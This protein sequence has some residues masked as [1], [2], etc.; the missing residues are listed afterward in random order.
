M[1]P[2]SPIL[3][4]A[5]LLAFACSSFAQTN[6]VSNQSLE[7]F[8]A[9]PTTLSQIT[10]ATGWGQPT[11]HTGSSD[12]FNSCATSTIS[13]VPTN[14]FGTTTFPAQGNAYAGGYIYVQSLPTYREY[15]VGSLTTPLVAGQSYVVSFHYALAPR[16]RYASDALGFYLSSA[17]PSNTGSNYNVL[18]VTPNS[19]NQTGNYLTSYS[20]QLYSDTIIA[21]GGEQYIT[22][23]SFTANAT[24]TL[25][26]SSAGIGGAYMYFDD[27]SILIHNGVFGDSNICLGDTAELYG[28]F[29]TTF[30]WVDSANPNTVL[31]TNDTIWVAPTQNST[32]WAIEGQDTSSF[33]VY[34]HELPTNFVGPDTTVCEGDTAIRA[35]NLPYNYLWSD[36]ETDSVLHTIQGG[37]HWLE[38]SLYGCSERDTFEVT[39][40][41][42]P[43]FSLP[44]DTTI[45]HY[46]NLTVST[47]LL[48]PLLFSWNTGGNQPSLTVIDSGEY[49]V[50]VTNNNCT[51]YDT[52]QVSYHPELSV[53]LGHD[54][55]FC[56]QSAVPINSVTTNATQFQWSN[57]S[58]T[59][60]T[61]VSVSGTYTLTVSNGFCNAE[62]SV[63]YNLYHEPV[64]DIGNDTSFCHDENITLNTNLSSPLEFRWNDNSTAPTL[65]TNLVGLYWVEVSDEHCA[66]RDS[67]ILD[68]YPVLDVTLGEDLHACEG[69]T[70]TLTPQST[71][72]L[73]T[74]H[75]SNGNTSPVL[76]VTGHGTYGVSVSDGHCSAEDRIN[77]FYHEYPNV[78]IGPDTALCPDDEITLDATQAAQSIEYLWFDG[79]KSPTYALS[80]SHNSQSYWVE[81]TNVVCTTT[82]SILISTRDVPNT[83]LGNDTAICEGEVI[84]LGMAKDERIQNYEWNTDATSETINVV[85]AG[86]YSVSVFDGHCTTMGEIR[87]DYR[88]EPT[89]DDLQLALP[90]TIC[91]GEEFALNVADDRFTAYQ[92]QDGTTSP[93]YTIRSE[94]LYWVSATHECGV[95]TDTARLQRCECPVWVP[96]AFKPDG[97]AQ[98]DQFAPQFDCSLLKYEFRVFDRWGQEVFFSEDPNTSWDGTVNGQ[99][100]QIGQYAWQLVYTAI[101][102]GQEVKADKSGS[103]TLLR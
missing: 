31:S 72:P 14:T 100:A 87:I 47:G 32:Y 42:F 85:Q 1:K 9:C 34:V 76:N 98:N 99:R 93:K 7:T 40:H 91:L 89:K 17:W 35:T 43:E 71:L 33:S 28:I 30:Y 20:W 46:D 19:V 27:V 90:E 63:T 81:V 12:Y 75:W 65:T 18:P 45:C 86:E 6:L 57:G 96:T 56:Y 64:V 4:C 94:G 24:A 95:L 48:P 38:I 78:N 44:N 37:E 101:H 61:S 50:G 29:D 25:V 77:V 84:T 82:D 83:Y 73:A 13:G 92:W 8:S 69:Q 3:F 41:Q 60:A 97:N 52:I 49:S 2:N 88:D 58:T 54:S 22:I 21:S 55:D 103:V 11:L 66:M 80:H 79:T 23:G 15:V 26:S 74:Y 51:F 10:N 59:A 62:D 70:T 67:I 39:F 102:E 36:S 5:M 68:L 16:S 53:E